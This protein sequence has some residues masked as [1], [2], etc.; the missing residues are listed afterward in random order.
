M[1][2][3]PR[4]AEAEALGGATAYATAGVDLDAAGRLKRGIGSAVAVTR[5]GLVAAGFGGFGGAIAIPGGY[6]DPVL[7]ASVDGVGTKLHLAIEW[8]RPEVAGRDLVNH[9][10]NDVA[11][12]GAQP[13]AFLDYVAG[14]ELHEETVLSLVEGMAEAC[15][16]AGVA[17]IGGETAFM[18]DT[19]LAGAYD[20]AG[21]MLGV[22]E[23]GALPQPSRVEIGDAIVGL[24]SLGLHTNGYSL[25]RR[26]AARLGPDH[27][28]GEGTLADALLAPHPSY[29]PELR[30]AFAETGVRVAAHIT[31]GGLEENVPRVLPTHVAARFDPH[32]WAVPP[33]FEVIARD[34]GVSRGEMHRVFNM[35]IGMAIVAAADAA[36]RLLAALPGALH[37]GEVV[38]RRDAAVILAGL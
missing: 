3:P 11:V 25:A 28:V 8:G 9:G 17:L 4:P 24:P 19:Y 6:A 21:T 33:V 15:R 32:S 22:A 37:V 7:V 31:G 20:L 14:G 5:T 2:R 35:G 30:T 12:M 29:L 10:I 23:R 36:E 18:P 16:A 13:F 38:E 1:S 34:Q 27:P 26:T